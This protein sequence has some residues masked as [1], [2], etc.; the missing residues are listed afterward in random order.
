MKNQRETTTE[1]DVSTAARDAVPCH[2]TDAQEQSAA[3]QSKRNEGNEKRKSGS[4]PSTWKRFN[5]TEN[6]GSDHLL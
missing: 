3:H 4:S 6:D 1:H 2:R 5:R